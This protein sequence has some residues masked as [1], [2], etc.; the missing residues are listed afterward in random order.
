MPIAYFITNLV[1]WEIKIMAKKT[2]TN[3]LKAYY[4]KERRRIQ[5]FI[6][7]ATKRGYEF[8]ESILPKIPKKITQASIR[9]LKKLTPDTLYSK[10]IYASE[11]T[12]GEIIQGKKARQLERKIAS[13]KAAQTRK[14]KKIA[15]S[16]SKEPQVKTTTMPDYVY[17]EIIISH[18]IALLDMINEYAQQIFKN[19]LERLIAQRGSHDVAVM[20]EKAAE[21]GNLIDYQVIYSS[22]RLY[23]H[24]A[25]MMSYLPDIGQLELDTFMDALEQ[26][27]DIFTEE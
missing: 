20:L 13:Q 4:M 2:K 7:R 23:N 22:E 12:Y 24:I 25:K 11:Q 27:E 16:K 1:I 21:D 5:S 9:R 3:A 10:A 26:E 15:K 14:I 18:F 17:D 19:W 6:N 8:S